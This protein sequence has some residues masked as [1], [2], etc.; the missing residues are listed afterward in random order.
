MKGTET[1]HVFIM[2]VC[3]KLSTLANI[4]ASDEKLYTTQAIVGP[5]I[6]DNLCNFNISQC[7]RIHEGYLLYVPIDIL[8][9]NWD[10]AL[11]VNLYYFSDLT[12]RCCPQTGFEY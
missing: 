5:L 4:K 11:M 3:H 7:C 8:Q 1:H 12:A 2:C 6:R 10:T 9:F